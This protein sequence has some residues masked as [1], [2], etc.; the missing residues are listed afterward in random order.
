MRQIAE[1]LWQLGG[2]PPDLFNVYLAGDV[3]IDAGTRWARRRIIRHCG[4]TPS[5]WSP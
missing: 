3:L 5:G 1:G 2:F 4:A